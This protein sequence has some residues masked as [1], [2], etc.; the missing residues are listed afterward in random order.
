MAWDL[1]RAAYDNKKFQQSV[2]PTFPAYGLYFALAGP[3]SGEKW[4]TT[5]R[6]IDTVRQYRFSDW[7]IETTVFDRLFSVTD[8]THDPMGVNLS[9]DGS[10]MYLIDGILGKVFQYA[11]STPWDVDTASYNNKYFQLTHGTHANVLR[12]NL[13]ESKMYVFENAEGIIYQYTLTTP[14]DVETAEYSGYSLDLS[15]VDTYITAM[16]FSLDGYKLFVGQL[17]ESGWVMSI[18]Q[19]S[20]ST[21]WRISTATLDMIFDV[22]AQTEHAVRGLAFSSDGDKM[23]VLGGLYTGSSWKSNVFQY[24]LVFIPEGTTQAETD[25]KANSITGNGTI[26]DDGGGPVTVR[27]F[28]YMEGTEGDPTT[29]DVAVYETGSFGT[30]AYSILVGAMQGAKYYR[31]RAFFK[32]AAGTGYGNTIQILTSPYRP[33][34][35]EA[36]DGVHTNKVVITWVKPSP[37]GAPAYQVY[38]DGVGLGWLGDVD[39]YDDTEAD[40][41]VIT[42]G[43]AAASDGDFVAHVALSL[44]GQSVGNG[45]VHTYKVKAKN[46]GGESEYGATNT[47][48]RGVDALTYQW[49]RSAADDDSNY[50]NIPGATAANYND[51]GAPANGDNRYY[52]CVINA[53]GAAEQISAVDGGYRLVAEVTT[54]AASSV[55]IE[56]AKGNGTT[57]GV[58][59]TQRG[60]KVRLVFSG[61]LQEYIARGMAGFTGTIYYNSSTSK[62]EGTLTKTVTES[63]TFTEGAY[64]GDLGHFP[65]ALTTDKLFASETYDYRAYATIDGTTYY[66]GHVEFTTDSHPT[67]EVPDD[68]ISPELPIIEPWEEPPPFV[69][70]P[71]EEPPYVVPPWEDPAFDWSPEP[72]IDIS[73]AFGSTFSAFM[74]RL[75]SK[76]DWKTLREKCIIYQENMNQFVLTVNH[77][78]LVLKNLVNDIIAYVNEDV[79]PS[80]LKFMDSCQQLT[81]LYLEFISPGGF[82]DI[83]NDFR[84][85][86]V[87]S[88]YTLNM[89]FRKMLNSLNSLYESDYSVKPIS[90]NA[91]EY[92][93]M[94]PSAKRMILHLDDMNR[95]SREVRKLIVLNIRRI[96]TYV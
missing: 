58:N 81:P 85:K 42:P 38:R 23:Y 33:T 56:H 69:Y 61:T 84:L 4:W 46:D 74:R 51:T 62:W 40:A 82:K 59:I 27:G 14:G 73:I 90:Y 10:K 67:G 76:K 36:T 48:Y 8:Q 41:P 37:R 19:Y 5:D 31:V 35:V 93:D 57:S 92:L 22:S 88:T 68:V 71:W 53:T 25:V 29:A 83:I 30:G 77:N 26:T 95:K 18:R 63:G 34:E 20:L 44:S 78:M 79:Y 86:D 28:C 7:D 15:E 91:S 94:Q 39:T 54:E 65:V 47:G 32:T 17:E 9:Y 89:N 16:C 75:D 50:S 72:G 21:A 52:R 60:F 64:T 55:G 43:S 6:G 1:S 45:T 13:N 49:Q 3:W 12:F 24:L 87:C 11:L 96:F 70:D 2:S 66:G 80:D